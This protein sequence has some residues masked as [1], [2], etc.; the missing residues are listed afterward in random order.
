VVFCFDRN[1]A[2]K[3][4]RPST[5]HSKLRAVSKRTSF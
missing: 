2:T 1:V 3:A 4:K 5:S